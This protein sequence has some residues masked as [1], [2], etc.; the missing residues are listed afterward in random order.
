MLLPVPYVAQVVEGACG[1]AA[2]EMVCRHFGI[3]SPPQ[4]SYFD[5]VKVE[6]PGAPGAFGIALPTLVATARNNGLRTDWLRVSLDAPGAAI[7][8]LRTLVESERAPLIVC[9]PYSTAEPR[10]AHFRLV[11]GIDHKRLYLHD[12]CPRTGGSYQPRRFDDFVADWKSI[13]GSFVSGE[14]IAVRGCN[15]GQAI[16]SASEEQ[17]LI[18]TLWPTAA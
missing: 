4:L 17:P 12:P 11:V 5:E 14:V 18:P 6:Q 10:A 13:D 3:S 1:A 9:Q 7:M 15:A 8:L 16:R 2:L